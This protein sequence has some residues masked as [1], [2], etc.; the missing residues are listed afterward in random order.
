LPKEVREDDPSL[1]KPSDDELKEVNPIIII[2]IN[3]H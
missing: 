2:I 3:S 1:Q